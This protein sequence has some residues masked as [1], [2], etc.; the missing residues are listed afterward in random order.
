MDKNCTYDPVEKVWKGRPFTPL[1]HTE[2]N[3][4]HTILSRLRQNPEQVFQVSDDTGVELTNSEIYSRTLKFANHLTGLGVKQHDVVGLIALNSENVAPLIF[5]CLSIG[6][7]VNPLSMLMNEKDIVYHW[8]KTQP[9]VVFIDAAF[10]PVVSKAFSEMNLDTKIYS[11]IERVN[12]YPFADD[13]LEE[14]YDVEEY[15]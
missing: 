1:Y 6:A 12:G 5:S 9:K 11:L 7:A 2:G 14:P 3:L 13:I 4:G 10:Y 8:S 15:T